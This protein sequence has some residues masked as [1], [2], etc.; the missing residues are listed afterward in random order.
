MDIVLGKLVHLVHL[1]I[2]GEV[3]HK[4]QD[5]ELKGGHFARATTL[6]LFLR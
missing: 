1:L 4:E 5:F 3:F 2:K 6:A